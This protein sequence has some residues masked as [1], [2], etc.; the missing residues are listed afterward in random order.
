MAGVLEIDLGGGG[1]CV[2]C[3]VVRCGADGTW[4]YTLL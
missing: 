2:R 1:C 4:V 3:G